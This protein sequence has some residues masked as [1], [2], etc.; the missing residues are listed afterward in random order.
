MANGVHAFFFKTPLE[1]TFLPWQL[2]EIFKDKIYEPYLKN[3]KDLIIL[4]L[5][6]FYGNFSYYASPFAKKIYGFEPNKESFEV[7]NLQL[8]FNEI[9]NV[10]L[11]NQAISNKD[12]LVP[13]FEININKTM[14]SLVP[15]DSN[16]KPAYEIQS[17]RLDTFMSSEDITHIDFMKC[18]I[19]GG[20]YD[21]FGG[22]GFMNV[23]DRIDIIMGEVHSW[24]NRQPNQLRDSFKNNGFSFE[25]IEDQVDLFLA[26][27]Q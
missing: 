15:Y 1:S 14:S 10:T 12:G 6:Y 19:E 23:A 18:D 27:R 9:K 7:A 25:S 4:D 16:L 26:K 20:E 24:A 13:F 17:V 2:N 5:G 8:E 3:K 21:L 22:D 11:Y